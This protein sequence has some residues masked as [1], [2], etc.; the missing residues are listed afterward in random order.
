M[1]I[2][3]KKVLKLRVILIPLLVSGIFLALLPSGQVAAAT[4]ECA[5]GTKVDVAES[6]AADPAP[7]CASHGGIKTG[8]TVQ[9]S[10]PASAATSDSIKLPENSPGSDFCGGEGGNYVDK[11]SV[12]ISLNIGCRGDGNAIFDMV[13]AILRFLSVAV[14]IVLI[15]SAIVAGIQFTT[16]AD[17][18]Q[19]K[20][21]A[22]KRLYGI[23]SA[24]FVFIMIWA[25]LN[26][27]VP[28]GLF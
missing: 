5:N 2:N 1:N 17:N 27:L 24:F 7:L 26:F 15:G 16:S 19:A 21:H 20:E 23:A 8:A 14:G 9:P 6:D 3:I 11:K 12:R 10:A 22:I 18:P 4:I 28:G 25:A 13:T